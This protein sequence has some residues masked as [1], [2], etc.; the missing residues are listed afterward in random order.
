M[1][2][3]LCPLG[4]KVK[5]IGIAGCGDDSPKVLVLLSSPGFT[6]D[7]SGLPLRNKGALFLKRA[8]A[9]K[10]PGIP[11]RYEYAV[12]C[13]PHEGGQ[14]RK[15]KAKEIKA[16]SQ[17]L[18]SAVLGMSPTVVVPIGKPA[19]DALGIKGA[20]ERIAGI[21]TRTEFMGR[22]VE[23]MPLTDP[24]RLV[25]NKA[26]LPIW[27]A[28]V[29]AL[30]HLVMDPERDLL[31]V[32][33]GR[34]VSDTEL[35]EY[36]AEPVVALDIETTGL[37]ALQGAILS[38]AVAAPGRSP[39]GAMVESPE[40]LRWLCAILSSRTPE[41]PVIVHNVTFEETWFRRLLGIEMNPGAL[42]DTQL[43]A[44]RAQP[45]KPAS[46]AA[47][48]AQFLPQY[49]GF[50]ADTQQAMDE[51]LT[52]GVNQRDLLVRNI[53]D[54]QVTLELWPILWDLLQARVNT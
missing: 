14:K 11:I 7:V 13:F 17:H 27:E 50:K 24:G 6:E 8:L 32:V 53:I 49:S 52:L 30:A 20:M 34:I 12:R 29:D 21:P 46:L 19:C 39:V 51:G 47:L 15:P 40:A 42:R 36:L 22:V 26:D 33:D 2:C 16:C 9:K 4:E 5:S 25:K 41:R 38:V 45:G 48:T 10:L 23:V 31:S 37:Q 44:I 18:F 28:H 35:L 3:T 1:T 43:L 54:A